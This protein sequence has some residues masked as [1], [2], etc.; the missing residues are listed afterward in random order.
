MPYHA[1]TPQPT[2]LTLLAHDLRWHMLQLLLH[3]DL[4][5]HELVAACQQPMNLVSYHLKKLRDGR[6]VS[7]RRSQADG[8]DVYY[9]LN[10]LHMRALYD[11]TGE[12]LN[13]RPQ[14]AAGTLPQARVLVMCTHNSARSQMAE[15]WLNALGQGRVV[16]VSAGSHPGSLRPEAVAAMQRHGVDISHHTAKS[17][18]MFLGQPFDYVITVCDQ[19]REVC[20]V[21]PGS[22]QRLHWGYDD[23]TQHDDPALRQAAFNQVA[24]QLKVRVEHFLSSISTQEQG[25]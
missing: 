6:I 23:P 4:R 7:T 2:L 18:E 11:E 22:G 19:A 8:R 13:L 17:A 25:T 1:I 12:A 24:D 16:A 15:G 21:F 20:P 14:A 10:L 9:S 3:S 5:V